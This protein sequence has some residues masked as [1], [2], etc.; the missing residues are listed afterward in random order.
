MSRLHDMEA[1][2]VL[3]L[4]PDELQRHLDR[5]DLEFLSGIN[6]SLSVVRIILSEAWINEMLA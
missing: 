4:P 1:Q 3:E 2:Q 5:G 6:H